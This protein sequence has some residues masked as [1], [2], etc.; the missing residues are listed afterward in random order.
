MA[1]LQVMPG[2]GQRVKR[3]TQL[4]FSTRLGFQHEAWLDQLQEHP[5]CPRA[6]A[7]NIRTMMRWLAR[8]EEQSGVDPTDL[9]TQT[10]TGMTVQILTNPDLMALIGVTAL[11]ETEGAALA[12]TMLDPE[13][14]EPITD[15]GRPPLVL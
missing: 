1:R 10:L 4:E 3:L 9:R 15:E 8:P 6:I 7:A 11:T 13:G 14:P 2:T 12:A 5:D